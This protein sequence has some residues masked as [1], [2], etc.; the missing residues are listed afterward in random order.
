MG[1]HSKKNIL[2][3]EDDLKLN[4]GIRLALKGPEY[5][6]IQCD[7]VSVSYTHLDV[8][9]RQVQRQQQILF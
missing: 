9:K 7:C 8:Y 1:T 5:D 3:V 6:C 2:I 4:N